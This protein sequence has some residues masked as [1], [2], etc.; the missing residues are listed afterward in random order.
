MALVTKLKTYILSAKGQIIKFLI[1]GLSST[2]IDLLLLIIFKEVLKF[3]PVWAVATSQLFIISYNF[4]LNKYWSFAMKSKTAKQFG[5]YIILVLFNYIASIMLMYLL[6]ELAGF[7]YKLVRLFSITV[8]FS[9]NF[10]I[11]K[12]W[13]YKE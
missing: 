13:V 6:Y 8:L 5:R 4:L 7:N 11:Y 1:V 2:V 3:S 12:H 9:F 10:I